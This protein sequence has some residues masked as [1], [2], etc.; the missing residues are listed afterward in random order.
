LGGSQLAQR[1]LDRVAKTAPRDQLR[2]TRL[3][4]TLP[5]IGEL[6]WRG[7]CRI[8]TANGEVKP[9]YKYR[10]DAR[11]LIQ[12]LLRHHAPGC[13]DAGYPDP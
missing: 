4:L 5:E 7:S 3:Q 6:G 1:N 13:S 9:N 8:K 12:T 10:I 2:I 11:R